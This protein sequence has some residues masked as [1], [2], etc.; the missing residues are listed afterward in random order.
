VQQTIQFESVKTD[1]GAV[2]ISADTTK[3]PRSKT[4]SSEKATCKLCNK[5]VSCAAT[6]RD[7]MRTHTGERPY[8]CSE[9]DLRFSQRSNLRMHKRLHTGERPYMCGICG[10]TFARSSHLPAHMRTHTGEKPYICETCGHAFITAQQLKNHNRVHTG[11]KP[12]K[13]ECCNAA[14]THSSSLSTHKKK[15]TGL[16]PFECAKCSKRFFFSS[17]LDKHMKVHT[18][19]RP[20]QCPSCENTFKYKESLTVH[21][22]RYC[23]RTTEKKVRAPR[24][25]DAMKPGPKPG[26]GRKYVQQRKVR[27]RGRPRKR[28]RW[29]RRKNVA[30]R[31]ESPSLP[32]DVD[33][34]KASTSEISNV[35]LPSPMQSEDIIEHDSTGVF[36]TAEADENIP[37][38]ELKVETVEGTDGTRILMDTLVNDGNNFDTS[39]HVGGSPRRN[40]NNNDLNLHSE[41]EDGS[42]FVDHRENNMVLSE[43]D[44]S[45]PN[46]MSLDAS[47]NFTLV[48][49]E[50]AERQMSQGGLHYLQL[51]SELLMN[52]QN[53]IITAEQLQQLQ[54]QFQIQSSGHNMLQQSPESE[55]HSLQLQSLPPNTPPPR[56]IQ[57]SSQHHNNVQH[58]L[59]N[60]HN[61]NDLNGSAQQHV[62]ISSQQSMHLHNHNGS[63]QVMSRAHNSVNMS[64]NSLSS[65]GQDSNNSQI[66]SKDGASLFYSN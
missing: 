14:F 63:Q 16:K 41:I 39:N 26:T 49:A 38:A 60:S 5:T 53:Q 25:A 32:A 44:G 65:I 42:S 4:V 12:W 15:H 11:E 55:Q 66:L 58:V 9:C 19:A 27:P 56:H 29:N 17:A 1:P 46:I 10:K 36:Y 28:G 33:E 2:F 57:Q 43:L 18:K 20:F 22:E 23:G 34:T 62:Q 3:K 59:L 37:V 48:S 7:H 45:G 51:P 24:K 52:N 47:G 61:S 13:C 21:M 40:S 31:E 64:H 35:F 54:Q 6:L 8:K 50:E 30:K